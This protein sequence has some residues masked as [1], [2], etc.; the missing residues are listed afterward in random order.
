[1]NFLASSLLSFTFCFLPTILALQMDHFMTG[2]V[3]CLN[4]LFVS[5]DVVLALVNFVSKRSITSAQWLLKE[6][7]LYS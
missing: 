1:V 4:L 3:G 5:D 2:L 7:P 6:A